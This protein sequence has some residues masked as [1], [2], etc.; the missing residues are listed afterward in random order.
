MV[1]INFNES[2]YINLG[3]KWIFFIGLYVL[4]FWALVEQFSKEKELEAIISILFSLLV[5]IIF[6]I[7]VILMRL[8]TEI[9]E[10]KITFRYR[11]FHI[12][13]RKILW[14]EV[15]EFYLR[16]FKPIRE[17]GGHGIQIRI[18]KG[19]SYTVSGSKGLQLI[20]KDG[21]KILI[22]TNK[23]NQLQLLIDRLKQK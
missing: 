10:N 1:N 14:D 9:D 4:M 2:Q 13:P 23:P 3:W 22:G 17:Y 11:P 20:L 15:S 18:K 6:N 7:I 8:D 16:S 12:R 21:K 19:R 5:I